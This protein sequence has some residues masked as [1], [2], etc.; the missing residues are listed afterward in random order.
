[1]IILRFLDASLLVRATVLAVA[2]APLPSQ[3]VSAC[4]RSTGARRQAIT[5]GLLQQPDVQ[6]PL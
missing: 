1:M 2:K 3:T 6:G 4:Y 5:P